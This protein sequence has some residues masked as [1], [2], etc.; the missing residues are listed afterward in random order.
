M[1]ANTQVQIAPDSKRSA[2]RQ[3]AFMTVGLTESQHGLERIV[4]L[5]DSGVFELFEELLRFAPYTAGLL[6]AGHAVTGDYPG[7]G[8]YEVSEPFGNWFADELIACGRP[9]S[10]PSTQRCREKLDELAFRFYRRDETTCPTT[11]KEAL[12]RVKTAIAPSQYREF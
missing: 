7:V 10:V 5:W 12:E 2:I 9:A 4:E 3:G 8:E 6:A 11:L 1:I